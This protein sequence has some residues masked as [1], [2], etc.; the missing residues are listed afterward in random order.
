MAD[1]TSHELE[2]L[3]GLLADFGGK[4]WTPDLADFAFE[5]IRGRSLRQES[6][7]EEDARDVD[8]LTE[9]PDALA[10]PVLLETIGRSA[11]YYMFEG[12][13]TTAGRYRQPTDP[14]GG[15]VAFGGSKGQTTEPLFRGTAARDLPAT[16]TRAYSRLA[17]LRAGEQDSAEA[18]RRQ[19]REQATD[20]A[21]LFYRDWSGV[22]PFYDGNGRVGRYVVNRALVPRAR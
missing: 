22:H 9:G 1:G 19:A 12:V 20:A 6:Y 2:N 13:L 21:V 15:H 4:G 18:V 14:G 11:H 10:L 8:D 7:L 16:V 17:D 5:E 3:A